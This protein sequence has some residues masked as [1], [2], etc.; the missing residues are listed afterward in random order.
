MHPL[1]GIRAKIDRSEQ[2][3]QLL[4]REVERFFVNRERGPVGVRH[5][6]DPEGETWRI[7]VAQVD[8]VP[9]YFGSIIGDAVHNLRAALDQLV[10]E[11]AF[12]DTRGMEVE[13]TGFPASKTLDNFRGSWVQK[14]L[15][16]GLTLK[17]R[18][19]IKRFQ[20]YRV[21]Q[22]PG[23]HHLLTFLDD[24]SND[25]KHRL[26]QPVLLAPEGMTFTFPP[27]YQGH[28]CHI[29]TESFEVRNVIG[30]P[31]QA[32]TELMRAPL[33]ITGPNPEMPVDCDFSV[34]IGFRDG[35]PAQDA[36]EAIA[37]FVREIVGTFAPEF[38]TRTALRMRDKPRFGRINARPLDADV[39]VG[40]SGV[41]GSF[42]SPD[43][44]VEVVATGG[45]PSLTV[46]RRS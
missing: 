36:L 43:A 20:P 2:H 9:V 31:L 42:A 16:A 17:H 44:L 29:A 21:R 22:I 5:E 34:A 33:A 28:N 7:V 10:F 12:I 19:M 39:H 1:E 14:R 8:D 23:R 45:R 37:V 30:W 41:S 46:S 11:L 32:N 13:T 35:T 3:V 6:I 38:E 4:N 26:T 27:H 15:L 24:L 25:D 18:T 40:I